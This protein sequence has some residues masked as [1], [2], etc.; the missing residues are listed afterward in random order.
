M[1]HYLIEVGYT[2]ESWSTQVESQANVIDRISPAVKAAKGKIV[3]LY[4]CFGENDLVGIIDFPTAEDAG[5]FG[6]AV[7]ASGALRSYKTTPLL[8]VDQGMDI[9]RRASQV[10][11]KYAPPMTVDL[12]EPKAPARSR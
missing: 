12:V 9:M 1:S 8:T 11:A 4:Y 7:T 6:L 5:S 3:S 10:R 2:P